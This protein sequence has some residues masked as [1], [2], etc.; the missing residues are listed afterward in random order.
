LYLKENK[1]K[2]DY[3][4]YSLS[5]RLVGANHNKGLTRLKTFEKAQERKG[6]IGSNTF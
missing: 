6:D 4:Q 1:F 3:R 2:L 5:G